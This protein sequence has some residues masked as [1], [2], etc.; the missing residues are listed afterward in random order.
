MSET[1]FSTEKIVEV[2][3]ETITTLKQM[4]IDS[5]MRRSRLCMHNSTE[6][7]IQEMVIVIHGDTYLQ[8]HRHPRHITESYHMVEGEM[9]VFHFDDSGKII[10]TIEMGPLSQG[11][12]L[13]YRL[14]QNTWHTV[15]PRTEYA[16]YHETFTGPFHK[17]KVVEYCNWAPVEGSD[18]EA[19]SEFRRNIL[20]N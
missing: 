13:A 16:V 11:K 18:P 2:T 6:D 8:P 19:I 3:N 1:I 12:T 17:D 7:Q 4:A 9:T 15:V 14:A 20:G 5:P 10:R